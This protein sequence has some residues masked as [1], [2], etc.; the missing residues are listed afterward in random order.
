MTVRLL[1]IMALAGLLPGCV[2]GLFKQE[3]PARVED[4]SGALAGAENGEDAEGAEATAYGLDT[5]GT[6]AFSRLDDPQSPLSVRVIYFEY[7]SIR[8]Q[9]QYRA[10]IEAHGGWLAANP[11]T[12][13]TLEGHADER[14]SRE[15]NLALG[16]RRA[17]TIKTQ[18]GLLGVT[19]EQL[20]LVS[21]GEEQPAA[22]GHDEAAWQQNRRV[23]IL[24]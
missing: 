14:G 23:E 15:Y 4:L 22:G 24:Y 3:Q 2:S 10:V 6:P 19:P 9:P 5:A 17:R 1:M 20:R 21:Y 12:V 18:L 8:V 13:I 16:E 7:D 11:G